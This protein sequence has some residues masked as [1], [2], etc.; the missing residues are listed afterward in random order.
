M[1]GKDLFKKETSP[2]IFIG[3]KIEIHAKHAETGEI[4]IQTGEITGTFGKG[5]KFKI[6]TDEALPGPDYIV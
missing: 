4:S 6:R 2:D 5:G 1:I 3:L